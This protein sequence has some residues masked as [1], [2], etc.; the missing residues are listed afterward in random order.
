MI[1]RRRLLITMSTAVPL[2]LTGPAA[3]AG[4][5]RRI[6][7]Y[8]TPTCGCCGLWASRMRDAG[9]L[10]EEIALRDLTAIRRQAA[11][12][13]DLVSCHTALF[14]R[15]VLEGH[16]PA[17]AIDRLSAEQPSIRGLAVPGMPIGSP[18]MEGPDPE[19]YD[20]LAFQA[21]GSRWVFMS[22]GV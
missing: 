4:P 21:D 3:W 1:D 6:T 8:L 19:P 16:V 9:F 22:I 12:P 14:G 18:G 15:Y 20:V 2:I 13:P 17:V 7:V 10:V 5:E 11:V